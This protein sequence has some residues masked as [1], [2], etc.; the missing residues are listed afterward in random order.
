[1]IDILESVPY[2]Q[3]NALSSR[4][5]WRTVDT[6]AEATVQHNLNRL[7]ESGAIKRCQ[8]KTLGIAFRW[9][10]WREAGV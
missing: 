5:I 3:D 8:Q 4:E 2:G 9:R 1:M 6:W 10:Y 7:A